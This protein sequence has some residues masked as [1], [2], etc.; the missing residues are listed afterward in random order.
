MNI[1]YEHKDL[2]FE[3]VLAC[4]ATSRAILHD[5]MPLLKTLRIDKPEQIN[6]TVASR[7]RDIKEIHINSLF[8]SHTHDVGTEDERT[9]VEIDL[10]SSVR[11][12]HYLSRF[13][14]LERVVFGGRDENG[15]I[16][17]GYSAVNDYF[18]EG[19]DGTYP[20]LAARESMLIFLDQ[21]SGAF[22]CGALNSNLRIL[23]LCCPD[24]NDKNGMRGNN[25]EVCLRACRSFPLQSVVEFE[26]RGSSKVK[27]RRLFSLDVCLQI[28]QIESVLE[29]RPG[30]K[31]MLRSGTRLL[32][33]LG[34]GRRYTITSDD[35]K[36]FYIV[37]YKQEELDEIKRVIEYAEL[38]VNKLSIQSVS[39]AI[40]KSF[41]LDEHHSMPLE[42]QCYVSEESLDYL[43]DKIGLPM[44][45]T[46]FDRS[47]HKLFGYRHQIGSVVKGCSTSEGIHKD[48]EYVDIELDCL[49][50][51]RR[52][53]VMVDEV[54]IHQIVELNVI[55][56]LERY[57]T[58]QFNDR[59]IWEASVA[60]N[61]FLLR[62]GT[63]HRRLVMNDQLVTSF[64]K[65]LES[66]NDDIVKIGLLFLKNHVCTGGSCQETQRHIETV[67]ST[68]RNTI[69]VLKS[70]LDSKQGT[71]VDNALQLLITA[72]LNC[73]ITSKSIT[74]KL[75]PHIIHMMK[76]LP[77]QLGR[78]LAAEDGV[79]TPTN[80]CRMMIKLVQ[81]GA[82]SWRLVIKKVDGF[83]PILVN[84]VEAED[85]DDVISIL[86][87]VGT[88][89]N[90]SVK[91]HNLLL[92]AG[93]IKPLLQVLKQSS[94]PT[95]VLR[96]AV[97][98]LKLFCKGKKFVFTTAKTCITI[99]TQLL[100][101]WDS[102]IRSNTC[103]ALFPI[104]DG[105]EGEDLGQAAKMG[106]VK[107]LLMNSRMFLSVQL[108]ALKCIHLISSGGDECV[109]SITD[110]NG[111]ACISTTLASS[112]RVTQ[113]LAC[114]IIS[115]IITANPNLIKSAIDCNI[116]SG[117]LHMMESEQDRKLALNAIRQITKSGNYDLIKYLVSQD[118]V[119]HLYSMLTIDT[120]TTNIALLALEDV[121]CSYID[122]STGAMTSIMSIYLTH[123][124]L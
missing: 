95:A 21:L 100:V 78:W 55:P 119:Y 30:G 32:N 5:A 117:L 44:T 114:C 111:I 36:A 6:L 9:N 41:T 12:V 84:S 109:Q 65:L 101:N 3:T 14:K 43:M 56:L 76:K 59:Y 40:M 122:M 107:H 98:S 79:T 118:C 28:A 35:G 27:S 29:A 106:F 62:G 38:D 57:L 47:L 72:A 48:S 102:D 85:N 115:N 108:P 83:L 113:K 31:E 11:I 37:K 60:V 54:T 93:I 94:T 97:G 23:G 7:F 105:M 63:K 1:S 73:H 46:E 52:F 103:W 86:L 2:N 87:A 75:Q 42:E 70:L 17:E 123:S 91:Y 77:G 88:I 120:S 34:Q 110:L 33:L 89:A 39:N 104:L 80:L 64:T 112:C 61:S 69:T 90:T 13:S 26:S 4:G 74:K 25:C 66:S 50:L 49:R 96:V 53:V 82:C 8:T 45:K 19:D 81:N 18:S 20:N 92:D 67:M 116:V 99:L 71:C 10:E 15:N 68:S 58:P 22:R 16:I 24:T 124:L 121:S 51:I